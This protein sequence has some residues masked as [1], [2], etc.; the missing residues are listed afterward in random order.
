MLSSANNSD[1]PESTTAVESIASNPDQVDKL[2]TPESALSATPSI[3]SNVVTSMND[4]ARGI[5]EAGLVSS[6]PQTPKSTQRL[7]AM[8]HALCQRRHTLH[9]AIRIPDSF[10]FGHGRTPVIVVSGT[11]IP[12]GL[13]VHLN[14]AKLGD[15]ISNHALYIRLPRTSLPE[16]QVNDDYVADAIDYLAT[17]CSE[18]VTRGQR[19]S[20][21]SSDESVLNFQQDRP[22][23]IWIVCVSAILGDEHRVDVTNVHLQLACAT[24]SAGALAIDAI[25][26]DEPPGFSRINLAQF[27]QQVLATALDQ[28]DLFETQ[29]LL[30]VAVAERLTNLL[31]LGEPPIVDYAS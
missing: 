6:D 5:T 8:I 14:F 10:F 30:S 16:V 23:R 26:Y 24:I 4:E 12:T 29:V 28:T 9:T 1:L 2:T 31:R 11:G 13:T 27:G 7:R 15:S 21:R 17:L 20:L 18:R 19:P 22:V 25:L 3:M